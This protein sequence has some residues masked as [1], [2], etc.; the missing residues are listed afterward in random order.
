LASCA[1]FRDAPLGPHTRWVGDATQ[2]V[3]LALG[4]APA[5]AAQL[6]LAARLHDVGKI[7]I[8]DAILLKQ[9]P[10]ISDEWARMAAHTTLGAQ[11]LSQPGAADGG[12]LLELAAQIALTH[13]ECWDGSGYPSGV[14]GPAIPLGGRVV[15]VVDTF[16]ALISERPYKP[17]WT[18]AQAL[19][20]LESHAGTLF[21]PEI[22]RVFLALHESG[23]LPE[24]H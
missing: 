16:D 10:L 17:G 4:R 22:V 19:A 18:P 6:G 9:G 23:R 8:P 3:A 24:R 1:E 14:A 13:H 20:Y 5:D 12:P 15:R 7:G 2:A 11:L 21:D